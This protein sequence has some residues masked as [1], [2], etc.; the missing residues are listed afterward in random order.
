MIKW[1]GNNYNALCLLFLLI[2]VIFEIVLIKRYNYIELI[3]AIFLFIQTKSQNS[4]MWQCG[5]SV[6][7]IAF[8]VIQ[9]SDKGFVIAGQSNSFGNLFDFY[10]LKLDSNFKVEWKRSIG[11][12]FN[13]WGNSVVQT[14]DGGY[15]VAG[16][17]VG[18]SANPGSDNDFYLVKLNPNGTIQWTKSFAY[19]P[20]GSA[21][22]GKFI[23][24]AKDGNYLLAGNMSYL[25][26]TRIMIIKIDPLGNVLWAGLPGE[27]WAIS[28]SVKNIFPTFD[29]GFAVNG[30]VSTGSV[31]EIYFLKINNA[32][33]L[34][35]GYRLSAFTSGPL[36]YYDYEA[37]HMIQTKD[38]GYV[39]TGNSR[40][41][42]N[43]F[44]LYLSKFD[45]SGNNQWIRHLKKEQAND[46][47]DFSIGNCVIQTKDGGYAVTGFVQQ[48]ANFMDY[49]VILVRYDS[50]GN[51]VWI[52]IIG[53]IG[54]AEKGNYLLQTADGGFVIAGETEFGDKDF[55]IIK[56]DSAGNVC[57]NIANS[58]N[59]HLSLNSNTGSVSS[60]STCVTFSLTGFNSDTL[61]TFSNIC[62]PIVLTTEFFDKNS[63]NYSNIKVMP[64]PSSNSVRIQVPIQ[65]INETFRFKLY[66]SKGYEVYDDEKMEESKSIDISHLADGLY[67]FHLITNYG[68]DYPGKFIIHH[69]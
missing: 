32:N 10:V 26:S 11:G 43:F 30:M 39:M 7:D 1:R 69:N 2:R 58:G 53:N 51:I 28:N 14:S 68:K 40:K 4:G 6:D 3:F 65:L 57:Q 37:N 42:T 17:T 62:G 19:N 38:S 21:E 46:T 15:L 25:G 29:G 13:D 36:T 24:K 41:G 45:K 49:D 34:Q 67:Y 59:S 66:N 22:T 64:N 31:G 60:F 18:Y 35:W 12:A 44:D 61:G 9:S 23:V 52:K 5:G 55:L 63:Y 16:T 54:L 27:S 48:A 33:A 20:S 8:S 47:L 50:G 56:T